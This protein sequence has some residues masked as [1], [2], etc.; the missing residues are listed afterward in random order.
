MSMFEKFFGLSENP[1]N[2]TPDPKFL[3]LSKAHEE[4]L[5]YLRYGIDQ[6]KGFIMITGEVGAGKTTICR[7]LLG[8][9]PKTVRTAL[10]L[11]PA[12][13]DIELLQTINQ[14]FGIN[15]SHTSKKALLDEL[16]EFLINV[17]IAGENAVLIIDECQN[18]SPDVLEQIRMLSNLE[19]EKEKLLQIVLVGQPELGE[20][21]KKPALRQLTQRV[22]VHYHMLPLQKEEI[23]RYINHRLKIAGAD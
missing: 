9:L 6:R 20:T 5:S 3:F 1:F 16:Y 18:L 22:S 11:N 10:I 4:S 21:L 19:T 12:L 15:A 17:F 23:E 2:V 7:A 13:S 14:D 8:N